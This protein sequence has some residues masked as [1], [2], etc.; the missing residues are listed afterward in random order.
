MSFK[1]SNFPPCYTQLEGFCHFAYQAPPQ[2]PSSYALRAAVLQ[3]APCLLICTTEM[4]SVRETSP[5]PPHQPRISSAAQGAC[6][7]CPEKNCSPPGSQQGWEPTPQQRMNFC[8]LCPSYSAPF[9]P[10]FHLLTWHLENI[11]S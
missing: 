3:A 7:H 1:Q 6:W 4:L 11:V 9:S 8:R 5:W 10:R 2:S